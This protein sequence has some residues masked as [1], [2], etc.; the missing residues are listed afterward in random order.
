MTGEKFHKIQM[1]LVYLK[2]TIIVFV[3]II[4]SFPLT[5]TVAN[6][7]KNAYDLHELLLRHYDTDVVPREGLEIINL[8]ITFNLMA[9]HRY[10]ATEETLITSAWLSVRWNDRSLKW[11]M[12]IHNMKI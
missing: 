9:L 11:E 8:N 12:E 10:D 2:C 7:Q 6:M 4:L 1:D 5:L 3:M